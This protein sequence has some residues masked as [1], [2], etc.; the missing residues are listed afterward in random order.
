MDNIKLCYYCDDEENNV[1]G[2]DICNKLTCS[3]CAMWIDC[4][5]RVCHQ[6]TDK[7]PPE[8][9]E[10]PHCELYKS[11]SIICKGCEMCK[12][13]WYKARELKKKQEANPKANLK[14]T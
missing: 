12:N 4:N 10:C 2:C 11:S 1:F 6:C 13:C 9:K 14:D 7:Q 8:T 5:H 3:G